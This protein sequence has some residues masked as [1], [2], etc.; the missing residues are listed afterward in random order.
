MAANFSDAVGADSATF[1]GAGPLLSVGGAEAYAPVRRTAA[2]RDERPTPWR[3]PRHPPS[4]G[5]GR[6]SD[7]A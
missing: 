1:A 3:K 6:S 4:P 7:R 5:S 2:L